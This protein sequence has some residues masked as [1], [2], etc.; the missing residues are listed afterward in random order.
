MAYGANELAY[1][2]GVS[3]EESVGVLLW[4]VDTHFG[5]K[6]WSA[7][8]HGT[9]IGHIKNLICPKIIVWGW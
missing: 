5:G 3:D 8:F 7:V 1:G 2:E 4:N 6:T 9:E